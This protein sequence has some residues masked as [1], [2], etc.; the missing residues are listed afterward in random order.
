MLPE[1]LS[2]GLSVSMR[3]ESLDFIISHEGICTVIIVG[4]W[5]RNGTERVR[6]EIGFLLTN[7]IFMVIVIFFSVPLH[8]P[9]PVLSQPRLLRLSKLRGSRLPWFGRRDW[10][11]RDPRI[12]R[13]QQQSA[14]SF[15]RGRKRSELES[16]NSRS[17]E[18]RVLGDWWKSMNTISRGLLIS[19]LMRR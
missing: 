13:H 19:L 5:H 4:G 9:L 16:S 2:A 10:G 14:E 15:R 17:N 6:R 8:A 18:H 12:Q 7:I 11:H 1:C 3:G